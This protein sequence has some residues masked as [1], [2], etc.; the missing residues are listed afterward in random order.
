MFD[1]TATLQNYYCYILLN[2][3]EPINT[4]G[5]TS[6]FLPVIRKRC[7]IN[8]SVSVSDCCWA[9][10]M[11]DKVHIGITN[12]TRFWRGEVHNN[13]TR[14][15]QVI[16]IIWRKITWVSTNQSAQ[17]V[18]WFYEMFKTWGRSRG[19]GTDWAISMLVLA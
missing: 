11:F 1:T 19:N 13:T 18:W 2:N 9:S 5:F 8:T 10:I 12:R 17:N 15:C 4:E 16:L 3:S 6:L 14:G 7:D